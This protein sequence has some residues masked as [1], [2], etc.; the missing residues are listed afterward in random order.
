MKCP[1]CGHRMDLG[2]FRRLVRSHM[3][4][5]AR[6]HYLREDADPRRWPLAVRISRRIDLLPRL[7]VEYSS[8]MGTNADAVRGPSR[9]RSL[10]VTRHVFAWFLAE[11]SGLTLQEIGDFIGR[12]HS[13]VLHARKQ[14]DRL[15]EVQDV[16]VKFAVES[17]Q[18]IALD[19]WPPNQ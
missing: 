7:L 17:I 11:C 19:I 14:V 15:L 10:V 9:L 1:S 18:Q 12:D 3:K 5:A 16:D 4:R 13:S 2:K 6:E 8:T